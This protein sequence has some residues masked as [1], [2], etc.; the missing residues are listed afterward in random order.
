MYWSSLLNG[1]SASHGFVKVSLCLRSNHSSLHLFLNIFIYLCYHRYHHFG[2]PPPGHPG[3]KE[4]EV[5]GCGPGDCLVSSNILVRA[6]PSIVHSSVHIFEEQG[7]LLGSLLGFLL[8][9][10][11]LTSFLF[12]LFFTE[13]FFLVL[14]LSIVL[15][16]PTW[17]F[18]FC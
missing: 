17:V 2:K 16:L 6:S 18:M 3:Q 11:T 13:G 12:V 10:E 14:F 5:R 9:T 8:L 7:V 4:G 15:S 1:I